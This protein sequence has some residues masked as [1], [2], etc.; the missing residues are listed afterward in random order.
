M[1]ANIYNKKKDKNS[2][3]ATKNFGATDLK[4]DM[5]IELHSGCNNGWAPP[6]Y[7]SYFP[8]VRLKMPKMVFKQK[9]LILGG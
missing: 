1:R 8:G 6:G 5:H 7:T 2:I 4:L 3:F 9:H